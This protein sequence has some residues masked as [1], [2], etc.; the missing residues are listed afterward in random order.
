MISMSLKS[1]SPI[2]VQKQIVEKLDAFREMVESLKQQQK[3]RSEWLEK[4][5]EALL[6]KA[7]RGK[8]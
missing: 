3:E 2:S 7:F 5:P 4:L 8:L 6:E 1:P